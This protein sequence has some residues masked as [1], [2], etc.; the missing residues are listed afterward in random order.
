[1]EKLLYID[2]E[3]TGLDKVKCGIIQMSGIVEI[4]GE[5]K[6]KFNFNVKPFNDD[7]WEA[8]ALELA[9][10][11]QITMEYDDPIIV[12]KKLTEIFSKYVDKYNKLDKFHMVGYNVAGFDR[13]FLYEWFRKVG[14]KYVGSFFWPIPIDVM[15][16]ASNYLSP[17]RPQIESF[18]LKSIA[19]FLKVNQSGEF[20]DASHD[21]EI[22]RNIYK[23]VSG[24]KYENTADELPWD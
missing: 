5:V 6:E 14:D 8:K 3:T 12:H 22:T 9:E 17:V 2:L 16:L 15:Y 24:K 13:D 7:V 10:S 23:V 18:K 4:N 20:H 19:D 11:R 21:I 1:M